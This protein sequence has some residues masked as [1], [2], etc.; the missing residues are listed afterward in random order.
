MFANHNKKIN[1]IEKKILAQHG[2]LDRAGWEAV[3]VASQ[4]RFRQDPYVVYED[5]DTLNLFYLKRT[6]KVPMPQ[7]RHNVGSIVLGVTRI[8]RWIPSPSHSLVAS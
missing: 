6:P 2:A 7:I 3:R 4:P 1:W 5:P 8:E